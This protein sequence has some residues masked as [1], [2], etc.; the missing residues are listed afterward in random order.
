MPVPT[1]KCVRAFVRVCACVCPH[2]TRHVPNMMASM[3]LCVME[4]P[5]LPTLVSFTCQMCVHV[6]VL[7]LF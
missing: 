6:F 7:A 4:S 1:S 2:M 3:C 5:P